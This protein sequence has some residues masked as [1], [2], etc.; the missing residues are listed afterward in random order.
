MKSWELSKYMSELGRK[1]GIARAKKLTPKQRSK[2]S[3][4][5]GKARVKKY[6][7]SLTEPKR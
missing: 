5:A 7:L 1:G 3:S 6:R 2:I 4:D